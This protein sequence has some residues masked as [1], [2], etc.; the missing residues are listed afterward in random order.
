MNR[1]RH[2]YKYM[3]NKMEEEILILQAAGLLERDCHTAPGGAY[4][5]RSLYFDDYDDSCLFDNENGSDLRSKFRMRYYNNDQEYVR[6]EKKSKVHGMT[7][8]E[9][10]LLDQEECRQLV[11]GTIPTIASGLSAKKKRLFLEM[12]FRNMIPKAIVS[13]ERIPFVYAAGNVRITFDRKIT[14]SNDTAYFLEGGYSER[15]IL[16]Q[17]FS[18]LEVKWDELLPPL[19]KEVM[20]MDSLQWTAFSKYYMCRIYHL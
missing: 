5:V 11:N 12:Q 17:G 6:L 7:K 16:S 13:Y 20:Q 1:Y 14:S 15:P 4:M 19:I 3:I 2:E 18:I 10:C 9:S 8:K